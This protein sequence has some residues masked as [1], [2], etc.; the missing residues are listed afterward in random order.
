MNSISSVRLVLFFAFLINIL[1]AWELKNFA[2]VCISLLAC[3]FF[4]VT[5]VK[6]RVLIIPIIATFFAVTCFEIFLNIISNN[7]G[8]AYFDPKSDYA[9][10][11]NQRI[12]GFGYLP[13]PGIHSSRKF[14]LN[15]DVIYDVT[16]SIEKDGYRKNLS[17]K[18]FDGFI[19]GGSFTFGEGLN[20]DE[21]LTAYLFKR[22]KFNFKNVGIHGYGMNQALYNIQNGITSIGG[23][24]IILTSPWHSLRSSCKPSYAAGTPLYNIKNGKL[25]HEGQCPG[26]SFSGL[27]LKKSYLYNLISRALFNKNNIISNEDISLYLKI[28]QRINEESLRNNSKLMIAYIYAE[29]NLLASTKWNNNS[30]VKELQKFSYKVINVTLAKTEED[31]DPSFYIHELDRHPSPKANQARADLIANELKLIFG[32]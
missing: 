7:T 24:N 13:K 20:D 21:T 1:I 28:I 3:L 14:G 15:G 25:V 32:K 9:S 18:P 10:G 5:I 6:K 12:K 22:H 19:F 8:K 23:V 31:L 27:V 17:K 11:Y 16:Y 2:F 26:G 29:P 4:L 30:L